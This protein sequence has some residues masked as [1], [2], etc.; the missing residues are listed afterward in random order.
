[1]GVVISVVFAPLTLIQWVWGNFKKAL[2]WIGGPLYLLYWVFDKIWTIVTFCFS[3]E[4]K[5]GY[6]IWNSGT[7]CALYFNRVCK[8]CSFPLFEYLQK[9]RKKQIPNNRC[10]KLLKC[11]INWIGL[12]LLKLWQGL[13]ESSYYILI[14]SILLLIWYFIGV[15]L[16]QL[17]ANLSSV[18]DDVEV[19]VVG[20]RGFLNFIL[21]VYSFLILVINI[22]RPVYN[23]TVGWAM[24]LFITVLITAD[25]IGVLTS[26]GDRI[27]AELGENTFFDN[28]DPAWVYIEQ[29][30]IVFL[31]PALQI[32]SLAVAVSSIVWKIINGLILEITAA[33]S[34]AVN[35]QITSTIQT[36]RKLSD[37]VSLAVCCFRDGPAFGCCLRSAL[38]GLLLAV[39]LVDIENCKPSDLDPG[40][41]CKCDVSYGGPFDLRGG[42]HCGPPVYG[43]E[44]KGDIWIATK[45][46]K[47]TMGDPKDNGNGAQDNI[48]TTT[49]TNY[50]RVC[51]RAIRQRADVRQN[52]NTVRSLLGSEE[53]EEEGGCVYRC[54]K[55]G[56]DEWLFMDC[57][58][59]QPK[60]LISDTCVVDRG[61]RREL[62][63][64][65]WAAHLAKLRLKRP[66]EALG[67][68][69]NIGDDT[70]KEQQEQGAAAGV[71]V[72][73]GDEFMK[74][75]K[76]IEGKPLSKR[77][78]L[79]CPSQFNDNDEEGGWYEMTW[80]GACFF[81]KLVDNHLIP[82]TWG[83]AMAE[84][85]PFIEGGRHLEEYMD[86][87]SHRYN[88]YIL[89]K[90]GPGAE[91]L[92][93]NHMELKIKFSE[94]SKETRR[95]LEEQL[96]KRRGEEG[97]GPPPGRRMDSNPAPE[98]NI[99]TYPCPNDYQ[100]TPLEDIQNCAPMQNWT[101]R[102]T[103][104]Y[105]MYMANTLETQ[106]DIGY[107]VEQ[108]IECWQGY[109]SNPLTDPSILANLPNRNNILGVIPGL[110]VPGP[111]PEDKLVYCAPLIPHLS[112]AP[113]VKW[114][115]YKFAAKECAVPFGKTDSP[116]L[117]KQYGDSSE[118]VFNYEQ[119]W[120]NGISRQFAKERLWR[121]WIA[122]QFLITRILSGLLDP[123]NQYF[124]VVFG[125]LL[126]NDPN[127]RIQVT[128]AFNKQFAEYGQSEKQNLFCLI[129][130][131][132]SLIW[133]FTFMVVPG[134]I[135][136]QV[137]M[138]LDYEWLQTILTDVTTW[139]VSCWYKCT[140]RAK[141]KIIRDKL[142][143]GD[144]TTITDP[145]TSKVVTYKEM[146]DAV[147]EKQVRDKK[148]EEMNKTEKELKGIGT[149]LFP[150][151]FDV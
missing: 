18:S 112:Y 50:E 45:T 26:G 109:E 151:D 123:V 55:E 126:P 99:G 111:Q 49:G 19:A 96:R 119:L 143:K 113:Q 129:V 87:A 61:R 117:C 23:I 127:T 85:V 54:F 2:T 37:P 106:V 43:C 8:K 97:E 104:R 136:L 15:P 47:L 21:G 12:P 59:G 24:K 135:F 11:L 93:T 133:F 80:R 74:W 35:G 65:L 31:Q 79:E 120:L 91:L 124:W 100:R 77:V 150:K 68:V 149:L 72:I 3:T 101:T 52:P 92:P 48:Q 7:I 103:F 134:F 60:M 33:V 58:M 128:M 75:V 5:F 95:V 10:G 115:W 39:L 130:N 84:G 107:R 82:S 81:L 38:R 108:L 22:L 132:G 66:M 71:H 125:F 4:S 13:W 140:L 29:F 36:G 44:R 148:E 42:A 69:K 147:S 63:G 41:F 110:G 34:Q 116:C 53:E 16:I 144:D 62:E 121:V 46:T 1:M 25:G 88:S 40:T 89:K 17:E 122:F 78:K 141:G 94:K 118:T 30:F 114:D 73:S 138:K 6:F 51:K 102:A 9:V 105:F 20:V 98:S 146:E 86:M 70:R 76:L 131:M 145:A 56:G 64:E 142:K 67:V 28:P 83:S 90:E 57:G 32:L 27:L 137:F 139:L 14:F